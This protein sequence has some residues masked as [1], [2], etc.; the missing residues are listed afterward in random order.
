MRGRR[1]E[2]PQ[3]HPQARCQPL[4]PQSSNP[5]AADNE[6]DLFHKSL[7]ALP[8]V[9]MDTLRFGSRRVHFHFMLKLLHKQKTPHT[10]E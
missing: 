1:S 2:S 4:T 5:N 9:Q 7:S 10:I 8:I 3:D 6:H